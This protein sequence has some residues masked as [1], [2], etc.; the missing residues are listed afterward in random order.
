MAAWKRVSRSLSTAGSAERMSTSIQASKGM[1][2]TEVPPPTR[3]TLKVVL[4]WRDFEGVDFGDGAPHGLDGIGHA[5]GAVAVAAGPFERDLV[6]VAAD[7][8][9]GDAEAGAIHRDELVDLSFEAVEEEALHAAQVAQAFLADIGDEGDGAGGFHVA[10]VEGADDGEHDGQAA[11]I[12]ADAGAFEDRPARVTLTSVPSGKDGVEVGGEYQVG[13]RGLAGS[14]ADHVAGRVH[15]HVAQA[16]FLEQALSTPVRG[17]FLE[18]R[19]GNLAEA[20]LQVDACAA[21]CA[22]RLP[23]RR[24]RW[25]RCSVRRASWPRQTPAASKQEREIETSCFRVA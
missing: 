23:W 11:A 14:D 5:E 12:V 13:P 1:A 24:A 8:D 2:L 25:R 21:R 9:V 19:R 3:P 20:G 16:E 7:A 22:G 10:L 18:R 17:P 15:A 4:G 6:A